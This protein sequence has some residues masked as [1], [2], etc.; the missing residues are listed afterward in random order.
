MVF[1]QGAAVARISARRL[2]QDLRIRLSSQLPTLPPVNSRD[3]GGI[4]GEDRMEVGLDG[5][6][7]G[8]G[9]F[10]LLGKLEIVLPDPEAARAHAAGV[11]G[12]G[13]VP[14]AIDDKDSQFHVF[15]EPGH[16]KHHPWLAPPPLQFPFAGSVA[17]TAGAPTSSRA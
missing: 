3:L 9:R 4:D 14:F 6:T 16:F 2:V 5:Q 1:G 12:S 17:R 11:V 7:Q 8:K 15:C 10:G 13:M